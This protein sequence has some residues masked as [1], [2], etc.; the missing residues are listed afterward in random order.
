MLMLMQVHIFLHKGLP[1]LNTVL[2]VG[3]HE[4]RTEGQHLLRDLLTMIL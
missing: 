3:S 2:Q 1:E 4:S